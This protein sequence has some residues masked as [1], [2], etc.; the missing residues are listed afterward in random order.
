MPRPSAVALQRAAL[1]R[2][3]GARVAT[4]HAGGQGR[5]L[6]ELAPVERQ[7]EDL[8][9]VHHLAERGGLGPDQR[10]PRLHRHRFG[11]LADL[12]DQVH[13]DGLAN[14]HRDF[15]LHGGLESGHLGPHLVA[16]YPGQRDAVVPL[17]V[18]H[19]RLY[20]VRFDVARRHSG[21]RKGASR[22][23]LDRSDDGGI[24][25]P[26]RERARQETRGQSRG[27]SERPAPR[28]RK[29]FHGRSLL[30]TTTLFDSRMILVR[31]DRCIL[32][33][34]CYNSDRQ[35]KTKESGGSSSMS[36]PS[37]FIPE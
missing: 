25:C 33:V 19:R 17:V 31:T 20:E 8:A 11:D 29:S 28:S 36:F 32:A 35:V 22:R 15:G 7:L 23:I 5:E 2:R 18:R 14:L 12:Q 1:A 30:Q 9:V 21:A 6:K 3:T 26:E 27:V 34:Y 10:R 13:A 4:A 16:A 24:L 37:Q